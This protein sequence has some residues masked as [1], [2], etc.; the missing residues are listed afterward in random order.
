MKLIPFFLEIKRKYELVGRERERESLLN[1][2]LKIREQVEKV[3]EKE[4]SYSDFV[5]QFLAKN[6]PVVPT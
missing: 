4:L 2:G 1:M 5:E 6:E 3:N